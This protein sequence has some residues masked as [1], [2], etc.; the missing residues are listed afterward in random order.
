M[1]AEFALPGIDLTVSPWSA[2]RE[3][4]ELRSY[5]VG[6]MPLADDPWTRGKG[7]MKALLYMSVEVPVVASPV[8]VTTDIIQ[9]DVNGLLC[10][11]EDDWVEAL[12]RLAT[13]PELRM[14]LGRAGRQTVEK[15]FSPA[16]QVP[17]VVGV[18]QR[19]ASRRS[20]G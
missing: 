16:A 2:E 20:R 14:R 6:L 3:L 18:L 15:Q 4:E 9:H 19:A 5:D 8:G 13:D 1:G 7:A 17:R 11:T 10:R 12:R